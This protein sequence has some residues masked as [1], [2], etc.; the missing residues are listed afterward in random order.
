MDAQLSTFAAELKTLVTMT[1][2]IKPHALVLLD[3]IGSGTDPEE[4]SALSIAIIEALQAQHAT[5]I[6]TTH[7]S[8]IKQFAVACPRFMTAT[9]AF[10]PQTL[11][12]TYQLLLNQVGASEDI[13]LAQRLGLQPKIIAAAQQRLMTK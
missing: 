5:I 11:R 1:N 12:P 10:D 3:E 4:G 9:M 13:W 8:A 2:E 6:A 7:F